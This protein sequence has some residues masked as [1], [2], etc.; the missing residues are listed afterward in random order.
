MGEISP[1]IQQYLDIKKEYSDTIL[2]FRLGDFYEMFYEDAMLASREL[3]LTLT[4][5]NCGN[6]EKAPMCGVPYH[7][8]ESYIAKLIA[9]NYKVA[10][11]EQMS[12]VPAKDKK[13]V[14]RSVVRV[15]TQGTLIESSMLDES[16]NNYLASVLISDNKCGLC[17]ADV[18]TGSVHLTEVSGRGL[19]D[20]IIN[21]FG[22]FMPSEVIINRM[23]TEETDI[24]NKLKSKTKCILN[25]VS[26]IHFD[27]RKARETVIKHFKEPLNISSDHALSA[28]GAALLYLME[29]QKS[30]LENIKNVDF[31]SG[32]KFMK[33]D[34]SSRRN[35]ELTETMRTKDKRGSLLWVLDKSKTS[36][37]KRMLRSWVDRPLLNIAVISKRYN[38]VDELV[39]NT[40]LRENIIEALT[41]INDIERTMARI[42][43]KTGNARELKSLSADIGKIP[44]IKQLISECKSDLLVKIYDDLDLLRDVY[45]LIEEAIVQEPPFSVRE[46]GMI[47]ECYNPEL[48]ELKDI[49]THG[50]DYMEK[51]EAREI[52][53][54]GIKKLKIKYNKVT[55]Y[56]IEIPNAFKELVPETYIR[57]Q[58]LVN[59]ERYVTAELKDLETKVLGAQERIEK[60]EY[61]IFSQIQDRVG[62][63]YLRIEKSSKAIAQLD[64][65]CSFASV[66]ANNNYT[67]PNMSDDGIIEITEGRHPVVEQVLTGAPFVANDTYLDLNS[68]R[69]AIITGPNMAGKSTY[70]RQVALIVLMAQIGSFVPA[71][72]ANLCLVDSVFTRV[73]ASDDLAAG[74][75]TFMIE[76]SEVASILKNATK[77]SLI[78]YDEIGRGT[79]TFDGMSI[80]RAVLEYTA[81]PKHLGAKTLFATHYHELTELEGQL[82]GVKNYNIAVKR[83]GDDITFLRRIIKGSAT[84]SYGIAVAKLAGVPDSIVNRAKVIL[85]QLESTQPVNNEIDDDFELIEESGQV[86]FTSET[87]DKISE[88]LKKIDINT[89]TPIEAMSKLFEL[90]QIAE[91]Q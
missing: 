71:K 45:D 82:D 23:G 50:T 4:G 42:V 73:G 48:D 66:A 68:D 28:L 80:A 37:G 85:K 9:K 19:T 87:E 52:E 83:R 67:R 38:A 21:E 14:D 79:S 29:M 89:L 63:E 24:I 40:I 64:V 60:L 69:C 75:S 90:K 70:M 33:L 15:L 39:N 6:G 36:M 32:E 54:T 72:S 91:K 1:M 47:K 49:L 10:I 81:N 55:G 8:A 59:A 7:S 2:L 65:L 26:D 46:G 58:T 86:S 18:S 17:F 84:G 16:K 13:V 62:Q 5:K 53:K 76:M 20:K 74:Q 31:Y 44:V 25:V 56:Y 22:N 30:E 3:S 43:Y 35:L 11:C 57:R 78:I 88:E 41:G 12:D 34:Y 61:E 77:K 51:M 27:I